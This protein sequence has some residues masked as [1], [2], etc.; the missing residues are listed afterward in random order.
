M[1]IYPAPTEEAFLTTLLTA[2]GDM[3]IASAANT[4]ARLAVGTA[5]QVLQGGLVPVW[6]EKALMDEPINL[7]EETADPAT[8]DAGYRRIFARDSGAL[9][10][11]D[12]AGNVLAL[13]FA[14]G[15]MLLITEPAVIA[16]VKA[17][18]FT[19]SD[20]DADGYIGIDSTNGRIYFRHSG[21]TWQYVARL[22]T[23]AEMNLTAAASATKQA[24]RYDEFNAEHTSATG[25]HADVT[26]TS[27]KNDG[28]LDQQEETA[29]LAT[30]ASGYRRVFARDH[31]GLMT[32]DDAG[33]VLALAFAGGEVLGLTDV[34][35]PSSWQHKAGATG[36]GYGALRIEWG[37][38]TL[39]AGT[40]AITFQQAFT[41]ILEVFLI[42]KTAANAMYPSAIG[43]SGFTANG[44]GTD[45]FGWMVVGVD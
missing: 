3:V 26:A 37:N 20:V 24:V 34:P 30:P 15:E 12:D 18:A 36:S 16:R 45:T 41:T 9:L 44:T 43:I 7:Q 8:P 2:K 19:D 22:I 33:N 1:P 5:T 32:K 11:K 38:D 28:P 4:P 29:D 21:G 17:G 23:Q 42:D 31:G 10:T 39:A 25:A 13:A 14:G 35:K 6:V 40:K 27:V